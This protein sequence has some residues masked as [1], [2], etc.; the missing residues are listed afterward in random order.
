MVDL[1]YFKIYQL[2]LSIILFGGSCYEKTGCL[3]SSPDGVRY[4][5]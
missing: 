2:Y 4:D 3:S 5:H 1:Q